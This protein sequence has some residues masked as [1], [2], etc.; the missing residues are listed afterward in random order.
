MEEKKIAVIG[1]D[2]RLAYIVPQLARRGFEVSCY[3]TEPIPE[4][5]GISY[6]FAGSFAEAAEGAEA[7]VCG[8][9]FEKNNHVYADMAMPDLEIEAFFESLH[10]GKKLFGG[11][12]PKK[13]K[14]FCKEK[15]IFYY[16]FMEDESLAIFNAVATAEGSILTALR[17]H[18]TNLHGSRCLVLGYGKCGRVLADKLQGLA[19]K[20]TV[21]ARKQGVL[22]CVKAAGLEALDFESLARK[23]GDFEYIFNTIPSK[24]LTE[25]ILK[26]TQ[27]TG[28]IVDIATG[29]GVDFEAAGKW[30]VRALLCPGLPGKYAPKSSA[31]GMAEFVMKNME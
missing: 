24:V 2:K 21:C 14:D 9:P 15:E 3:A 5:S 8:I 1:G 4:K 26:R 28:L 16:D 22:A 25:E 12:L 19:A 31:I 13:V 18:P 30:G 6:C 20:V 23:I 27:K 10:Q 29:G 11:V 17:E 7:I